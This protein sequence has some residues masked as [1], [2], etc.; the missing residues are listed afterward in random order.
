MRCIWK[1]MPS[2]Q[3]RLA[4]LTYFASATVQWEPACWLKIWQFMIRAAEYWK[5]KIW[6]CK[7]W[8]FIIQQLNILWLSNFETCWLACWIIHN[9]GKFKTWKF[10]IWKFDIWKFKI[11]KFRIWK[12]RIWNL[13]IRLANY[14]K[15]NIWPAKFWMS[16]IWKFKI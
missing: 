15:F 3:A 1:M 8:Q 2:V 10:R 5:F 11:W 4:S 6:P 13:K 16:K 14:W 12:F 7:I 9:Y